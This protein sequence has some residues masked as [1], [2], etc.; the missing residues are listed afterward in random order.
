MRKYDITP[1]LILVI[2]FIIPGGCA[3][4]R[5]D[6][7]S[8]KKQGFISK[9]CYQAIILVQPE[10]NNCGLVEERDSAYIKANQSD[11]KKAAVENLIDYCVEQ[12]L[13]SLKTA[14]LKTDTTQP[15]LRQMVKNSI[16]AKLWYGKIA[17][18]YYNEN[19]A[20]VI[21]YWLSYVNIKG[22]VACIIDTL[23]LATGAI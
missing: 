17:F 1:A 13:K 6:K 12:K 7:I 3:F 4:P 9:N 22:K 5:K 11:L 8:I 23:P 18:V 2:F 15:E 20:V 16:N 14:N 19:N 21:G 10:K